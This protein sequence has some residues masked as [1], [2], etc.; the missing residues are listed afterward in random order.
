MT[1]KRS[2]VSSQKCTLTAISLLL[3]ACSSVDDARHAT[4]REYP[5]H[6]D[7]VATTFWV[8][9]IL[10][11]LV[12]DGS[13][14]VSTY[15]ANWME[16]YGGCDGVVEDGVC[17]TERRTADNDYFPTSMEPKQN[18][19]YLDLPFDDVNNRRAFETRADVVPWAED[20]GYAGRAE[21]RSFSFLKNRWVRLERDGAVC[22]GQIQDAG[23]A[24]YDDAEY[25][26]GDADERPRSDMFNG[27]GLDVS[28]ALNGCLGFSELNGQHDRVNWQFVED[29]EVPEG[30]WTIIVTT[31]PVIPFAR[32]PGQR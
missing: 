12:S 9:E 3:T 31:T 22:Y 25:V 13:Q 24:L 8:G 19:F 5:W 30:P 6:T 20:P 4:K 28:P 21:D 14:V 1:E 2:K 26:F 11:P 16:N 23:P 17:K 29:D 7:I 27:A 15:D 32:V 18:P 10:D